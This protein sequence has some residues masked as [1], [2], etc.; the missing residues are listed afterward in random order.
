MENRLRH[1]ETIRGKVHNLFT[2]GSLKGRIGFVEGDLM[3]C[4]Q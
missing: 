1:E 3:S 4:Y 2:M